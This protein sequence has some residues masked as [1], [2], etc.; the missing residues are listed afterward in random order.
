MVNV[1]G[2]LMRKAVGSVCSSNCMD[3]TAMRSSAGVTAVKKVTALIGEITAASHGQSAGVEQINSA[4]MRMEQ[5]TQQNA[6]LVEEVTAA[7][8]SFEGQAKT[9]D[10]GLERFR[11]GPATRA[12]VEAARG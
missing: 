4:L 10:S 2:A 6:A 11:G 5:M 7:T 8:L 1:G 3:V 9:L 12:D